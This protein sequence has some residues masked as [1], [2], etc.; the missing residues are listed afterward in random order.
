L[1]WCSKAGVNKNWGSKELY[2]SE[3]FNTFANSFHKKTEQLKSIKKIV[4][5]R[6]G[7]T[8]GNASLFR[9]YHRVINGWSDIGYHLVIGNGKHNFSVAG[10]TQI[11]RPLNL[12]GAH[13][14]GNNED[15]WAICLID[16]ED[17]FQ[18]IPP[19]K[20]ELHAL[21]NSL[22][23][24]IEKA[25]QDCKIL[26]H[27]D[28]GHKN[29]PGIAV[30]ISEI[31]KKVYNKNKQIRF[32]E[33]DANTLDLRHPFRTGVLDYNNPEYGAEQIA[34]QNITRIVYPYHWLKKPWEDLHIAK[35]WTSAAH[36]NNIDVLL[37]TGPFGTESKVFLK[38]IQ[39]S[40]DWLQ[41][42]SDGTEA[43]YDSYGDL[44][45]F[46]PSSPYLTKYRLPIIINF[47]R[48]TGCDGL[49]F[50]IPW[51][52]PA[53]CY[54]ERCQKE[55]NI[56]E[57]QAL[58]YKERI[59]REAL[60]EAV[61]AIRIKFPNAWLT[62]NVAAPQIWESTK[63]GATPIS[64][65]GLFNELIVEWTPS[66]EEE[67]ELI[68]HSINHVRLEAPACRISHAWNPNKIGPLYNSI[69]ETNIETNVGLWHVDT[70]HV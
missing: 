7:F 40:S 29:C 1:K 21:E 30:P 50:D 2:L 18:S 19:S 10:G 11:G 15:S 28:L 68:R 56:L 47:L 57:S 65:S 31:S 34:K 33:A 49:F 25:D 36:K 4:I 63:I 45:M 23:Y 16:N 32:K 12:A 37:Y 8:C 6:S 46:C 53:A 70:L 20:I 44:L 13:C 42:K 5:H 60:M 48:E 43:T 26:R 64:L 62:A 24:L 14:K 9:W 61:L 17:H 59:I 41:R 54:C 39:D 66:T 55:V 51:I 38:K 27:S 35:K 52:V 22:L 67:I 58:E 3:N 69:L